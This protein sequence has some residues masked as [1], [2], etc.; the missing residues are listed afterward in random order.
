MAFV[1]RSRLAIAWAAF[2]AASAVSPSSAQVTTTYTYD[3][4]GQVK[5]VVRPANTV[6]Y[7]YDAAGNRVALGVSY[8]APGAAAG[9]LSVPFG[10]S[11]NLALPVS[12]E[13]TNAAIDAAPTK[14][15]VSISGTTATYTASGSNYGPDSF[16]YHAVGP[17]GNSPVQTV[18]VTIANPPAPVANNASLGVAY[19]ATTGLALPIT[20]VYTG[21]V[22]DSNPAKGAVS[23]SGT[24]AT[25]TATW[26]NY[27]ADSFTYHATGPGGASAV[28]TVSLTIANPPAPTAANASVA[29][30][31]NTPVTVTY[32][33]GGDY[34]VAALNSQPA[35]G[36]VSAPTYVNGVGTQSTYT[37]QTG[38]SGSDSWTFH[39]TSPG[40]NSAVYTISVSVNAG[41]PSASNATLNVGYNSAASLALPVSGTVSGVVI[42]SNPAKGTVSVSGTTATYT[43]AWP[44]YGV[45][46][47]TYH[48]TGPGGSSPVRTVSVN[49]ANGAAPVANDGSASTAYN[50]PVTITYPVGGDYAVAALDS[51]PAHGGVSAPTYVNGVGTQSTYTPQ[52]GYS[53]P[54]SWTFHGTSPFGNSPTRTFSVNVAAAPVNHSPTAV[55]D[56]TIQMVTGDSAAVN[57]VAND[58]DP[59]GDPLTVIAISKTTSTKADYSFSGGTIFV[60]SKSIKGGDSLTY[61]VSDGR[62]G[63]ATATLSI[64]VNY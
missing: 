35:H 7:T 49:I 4:Q 43:A 13:V 45:D 58:T 22:V 20:G 18:N 55:N 31:F 36:S 11:A 44:N 51:Q 46:S 34:A 12:G 23:V 27:G 6:A 2:A 25:Y 54:D 61:T 24:S 19:N 38:Y 59:D 39:G 48:A 64:F 15:T 52:A 40:G 37:P 3:L 50:T 1:A 62:G 41:P 30:A 60:T 17:G 53:G 21:L 33:V 5:A 56:G 9:S 63:T 8:P 32:P 26:P 16:T 47:F 28:R 10:G 29:T 14:G 42:D 57:V